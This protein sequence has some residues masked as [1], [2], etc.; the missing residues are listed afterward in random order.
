MKETKVWRMMTMTIPKKNNI[1]TTEFKAQS[2]SRK[3]KAKTT[4]ETPRIVMILIITIIKLKNKDIH[5]RPVKRKTILKMR[6]KEN[7][8]KVM[9]G[10]K[11]KR[12]AKIK[13]N[14]LKMEVKMKE[15]IPTIKWMIW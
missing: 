12:T 10:M 13:I 6:N 4:N 5:R 11:R 14:M 3:R 1:Q 8:L 9:T 7:C 15:P 2:T